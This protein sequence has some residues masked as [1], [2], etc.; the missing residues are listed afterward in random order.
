MLLSGCRVATEV[1]DAEAREGRKRRKGRKG[2]KGRKAAKAARADVRGKNNIRRN[3][4]RRVACSMRPVSRAATR[5][6]HGVAV[7][8]TVA[9][10]PC[11]R[12]RRGR[13]VAVVAVVAGTSA[14]TRGA[15]T[16]RQPAA[17]GRQLEDSHPLFLSLADG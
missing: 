8:G 2:R 13:R 14:E 10:A 7:V 12:G 1:R 16:A 17:V 3:S 4:L 5:M 6:R 11:R 9:V 15:T